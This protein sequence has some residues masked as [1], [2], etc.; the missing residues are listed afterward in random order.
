MSAWT[1]KRSA[2][3]TRAF[4][5]RCSRLSDLY[6]GINR[7][8]L[9]ELEQIG[10]ARTWR[11]I[12]RADVILL[13]VDARQGISDADNA[14]I[15]EVTEALAAAHELAQAARL[16]AGLKKQAVPRDPLAEKMVALKR[17]LVGN[18]NAFI[19]FFPTPES[20]AAD[21]V[22]LAPKVWPATLPPKAFFCR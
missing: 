9:K 22:A 7:H 8:P 14:I 18:R 13:L 1:P 10:I 12:E 2:R 16:Q 20:H 17:K 5:L 11:E 6:R 15:T 21:L 3:S 4:S 19:D